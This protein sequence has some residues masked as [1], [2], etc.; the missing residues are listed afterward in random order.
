MKKL[1]T[2]LALMLCITT[3]PTLACNSF[4]PDFDPTPCPDPEV[5]P[6]DPSVVRIPLAPFTGPIDLGETSTGRSRG[7]AAV[8]GVVID[9]FAVLFATLPGGRKIIGTS[10]Q[11]IQPVCGNLGN[12]AR[13]DLEQQLDLFLRL[14]YE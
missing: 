9:D 5:I 13:R 8:S 14:T 6:I 2:T 3:L 12:W 7:I 1:T 11:C 10:A 4:G